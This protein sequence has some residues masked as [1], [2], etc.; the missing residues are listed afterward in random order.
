MS[1]IRFFVLSV[2]LLAACRGAPPSPPAVEPV[3]EAAPSPEVRLPA[4]FAVKG[5]PEIVEPF[6]TPAEAWRALVSRL[7]SLRA[8]A[9][10]RG[11]DIL[12]SFDPGAM[13]AT[14]RSGRRRTW[15][16][17]EGLRLAGTPAHLLLGADLS[18][19]A[20]GPQGA[21]KPAGKEIPVVE[22]ILAGGE[23]FL[24]AIQGG[25]TIRSISTSG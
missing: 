11:R 3:P 9:R 20:L 25:G 22:A 13:H 4:G 14:Y 15:R 5:S 23:H 19:E 12:I 1:G 17:P 8:D 2:L 6:L 18:L 7:T 24:L 21:P 16:L 10:D